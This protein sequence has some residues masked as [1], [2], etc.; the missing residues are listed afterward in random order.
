MSLY[1]LIH[2][3]MSNIH[4]I[5]NLIGIY[6]TFENACKNALTLPHNGIWTPHILIY[7]IDSDK[8]YTNKSQTESVSHKSNRYIVNKHENFIYCIDKNQIIYGYEPSYN[9]YFNIQQHIN[10]IKII[11]SSSI[12]RQLFYDNEKKQAEILDKL[13]LDEEYNPRYDISE[14]I[15]ERFL[16]PSFIFGRSLDR[17][18]YIDKKLNKIKKKLIECS[19]PI[20]KIKI[21]LF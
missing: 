11:L 2:D 6:T 9:I 19:K 10:D 8:N 4:K 18:K 3:D 20:E 12:S 15:N 16:N 1:V 7:M 13:E 14:N 5:D 21:D 17:I